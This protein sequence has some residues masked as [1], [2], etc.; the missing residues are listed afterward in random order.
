MRILVNFDLQQLL[1]GFII[2]LNLDPQFP[3]ETR[4]FFR[5]SSFNLS[6]LEKVSPAY[7]SSDDRKYPPISSHFYERV[8]ILKRLAEYM[9]LPDD[10]HERR[11]H[12]DLFFFITSRSSRRDLFSCTRVF[13]LSG[14]PCPYL[15]SGNVT[16]QHSHAQNE[17]GIRAHVASTMFGMIRYS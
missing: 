7:I 17:T 8:Y 15:I 3:E 11:C 12:T 5:K 1:M 16:P 6:I 2:F 4:I 10:S 9:F 14:F 13:F